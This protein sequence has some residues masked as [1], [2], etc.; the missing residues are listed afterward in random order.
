METK[1]PKCLEN[2]GN[3]TADIQSPEKEVLLQRNERIQKSGM[4]VGKVLILLK[5]NVK[6]RR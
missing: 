6:G 4:V 1:N 5:G 2:F 3:L